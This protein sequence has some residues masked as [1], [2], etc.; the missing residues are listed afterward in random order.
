[1]NVAITRARRALLVIGDSATL[2]HHDYYRRFMDAAEQTG[3]YLSA[4]SDDG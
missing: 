1:M 4:W 3:A 2:A